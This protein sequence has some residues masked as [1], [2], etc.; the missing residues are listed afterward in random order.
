MRTMN[1]ATKTL[2][3]AVV[4]GLACTAANADVIAS[5]TFD[6]EGSGTGWAAGSVWGS[7]NS[8][9]G[10]AYT[11]SGQQFRQLATPIAADAELWVA[12]DV[13]VNNTGQ[14][15]GISLYNGGSELIHMTK[16][17]ANRNYGIDGGPITDTYSSI[18]IV[19][20]EAKKLL[21]HIDGGTNTVSMWVDPNFAALGTADATVVDT[22]V[23]PQVTQVRLGSGATQTLDNL[24]IGT[25]L[26]S[27][28]EPGS[29]ALL[30]LGGLLIA[31][32]RR[33]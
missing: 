28:P 25:S 24:I 12:F 15:A 31:R 29:L 32:R 18:A 19:A 23:L 26:A 6:S 30:S 16:D 22:D 1:L 11:G 14:W 27:V 10:G 2:V 4:A 20:G 5:D 8:V 13:T 21:Y 3:G 7:G 17:S 9:S 33:G